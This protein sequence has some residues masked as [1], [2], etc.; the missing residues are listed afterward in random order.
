M[1]GG[2]SWQGADLI[3]DVHIQPRAAKNEVVGCFGG[4]LKIRIAAPPV[5]GKANRLL[6]DFLAE[7]FGVPKR[8]V[9]L[10]AGESGRD[11]RFRVVSPRRVP[12][13]VSGP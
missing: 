1:A 11:K 12:G 8:D 5:D 10:L 2:I 6:I 7:M 3:V 13:F 9:V 4:R